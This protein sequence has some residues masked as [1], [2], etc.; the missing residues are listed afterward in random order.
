[1]RKLGLL[2]KKD[3]NLIQLKL[4]WRQVKNF[5]RVVQRMPTHAARRGSKMN[6]ELS[7]VNRWGCGTSREKS[8][9]NIRSLCRNSY[10]L[11]DSKDFFGK[12]GVVYRLASAFPLPDEGQ[13]T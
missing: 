3:A 10:R 4:G 7:R 9:P 11:G 2:K 5:V 1:M 13:A 12:E 6:S 8:S